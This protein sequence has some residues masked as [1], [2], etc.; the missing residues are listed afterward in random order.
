MGV[1]AAAALLVDFPDFNLRLAR[2]LAWRGIPIVYYVSPQVWAWRKGRVR[3]IADCVARMLVLFEFEVPFYRA[4][5]VPVT[6]HTGVWADGSF[7]FSRS[8]HLTW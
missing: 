4:H 6:T 5:G 8:A 2:E 1:R 3:V 7:S